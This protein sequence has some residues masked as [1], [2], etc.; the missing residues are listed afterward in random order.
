MDHAAGDL[1]GLVH[2]QAR[3]RQTRHHDEEEREG[4]DEG[5]REPG[6]H[7]LGQPVMDRG[8]DGVEHQDADQAGGVG[9][10][11]HDEADGEDEEQDR[12]TLVV[13]VEEWHAAKLEAKTPTR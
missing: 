5:R 8:K 3:E 9:G 6:A 4:D 7:P 12:G 13:R 10:E 2:D 11:R 1:L